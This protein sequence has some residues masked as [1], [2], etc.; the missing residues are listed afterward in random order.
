[1]KPRVMTHDGRPLAG[2][3]VLVTRPRAQA[4]ELAGR[5][6]VLG[7][8]PIVAPAISIV[9]PENTRP[10]REACAAAAS[11]AWIVFTSA[12]AVDAFME[13]LAAVG[14]GAPAL[15]GVRMCA[16]GPAT[17]ARL[18]TYG[19][20]VDLAP[21]DHRGEGVSAALRTG[22]DLRGTRLLL[23][24][25]DIARPA[26][27]DA[28]RAAGAQV[29][30]VT[31]YRT[32]AAPDW[33]GAAACEMLLRREIDAV[34]FTSASAVRSAVQSL[35]APRAVDL[36]STAVVAAIG[37]VT[38]RAA[39]ELGIETEVMPPTYTTEALAQAIADHFTGMPTVR[40]A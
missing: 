11:F 12:N 5:L 3:R 2:K 27:P 7:A 25:A 35:G 31:A 22:R 18:A 17:A 36:L 13:H 19:L 15:A 29:T 26:L 14:S 10:L 37:P 40:P 38:A 23:P 4:P 39:R 20:T 24:R 28:L 32:I 9:P 21:A 33:P 6:A 16:I 34:T 30:E 1:M 8:E